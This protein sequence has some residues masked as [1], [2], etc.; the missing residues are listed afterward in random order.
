MSLA[1]WIRNKAVLGLLAKGAEHVSDH[2]RIDP[3]R[4]GGILPG[5]IGLRTLDGRMGALDNTT[6]KTYHAVFEVPA[7]FDAIRPIFANGGTSTYTVAHWTTTVLTDRGDLNGSALTWTDGT[8]SS[9]ATSSAAVPAAATTNRRG[10]LRGDWARV[11]SSGKTKLVAIRAEI[12]TAASIYV[13][14]NGSDDYTNWASRSDFLVA[15]RQKAGSYATAA[16]ASGF[17]DTTARSQTPI[18][19]VE[20][21]CR[22]RVLNVCA[23]GDSTDSGRGTY[24]G[25]GWLVP[26][27]KALAADLGLPVFPV[28]TGWS[29]QGSANARDNIIDLFAASVRP[30][31]VFFPAGSINDF[32]SNTITSTN[33]DTIRLTL[34]RIMAEFSAAGIRCVLRTIAPVNPSVANHNH[35]ATDALRVAWDN[36]VVASYGASGYAIFDVRPALN[37]TTDADGQVNIA[38]GLTT[39]GIHPN[40]AGNAALAPYAA[41]AAKR[42][43]GLIGG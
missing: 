31:L 2:R 40:D 22:G 36:E 14:G 42:A 26:A 27:V 29:G 28:Q 41:A 33:V 3:A 34:G 10:Y 6:T 18:F 32:G 15:L 11:S 8:F 9:G 21:S 24:K 37:G 19:G 7:D 17:D 1:E 30:D 4:L 12:S 16:T 35:D 39:D 38:A 5:N 13:V 43:L 23:V 20:V 25:E